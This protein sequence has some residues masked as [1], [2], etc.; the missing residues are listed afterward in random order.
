[1][2]QVRVRFARA[3]RYPHPNGPRRSVGEEVMM[4]STLAEKWAA[5]GIVTHAGKASPEPSEAPSEPAAFQVDASSL[6][7]A[8]LSDLE[9]RLGGVTDAALVRAAMNVDARKGAQALYAARL[10]QLE[11]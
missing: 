3:K 9:A 1:M 10:E 11:Q 2:R 6:T 7:G 5:R 4:P 8:T